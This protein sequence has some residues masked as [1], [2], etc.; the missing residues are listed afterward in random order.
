[1]LSTIANYTSSS[2]LVLVYDLSMAKVGKPVYQ[3]VEYVASSV[4]DVVEK[5]KSIQV[6]D[7]NRR[8]PLLRGE[9]S[10][11]FVPTA[12][13]FRPGFN[14]ELERPIFY[15]F[16][17][18]IPVY[19]NIDLAN[20][21]LVLSL[22]QHHGVPTRLLDWTTS[23]LVATFFAVESPGRIDAAVWGV[24]G[25]DNPEDE[26]PSDPFAINK[27]IQVTPVVVTPRLQAQSGAFTAH[28]NGKD[29]RTYLRTGDIVV[30]IT[31]PAALR[32]RFRQQLDFLGVNR[33]SLFPDLDGM[34]RWLRW[35]AQGQFEVSMP[36]PANSRARPGTWVTKQ[37]G[38]IGY[39]W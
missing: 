23:P 30:K 25:F 27:P 28:P 24:W 21:W 11:C 37:T 4:N 8:R 16:L 9:D 34:G 2:E 39:T 31:I 36:R 15:E 18:H 20:R 33:A 17:R 7:E 38:N 3:Y 35:R 1:M 19:A 12:G 14:S 29:L 6:Q 10:S 26:F 13:I 32:N 22:A 5:I